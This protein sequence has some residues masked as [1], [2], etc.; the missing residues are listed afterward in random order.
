MA[1]EQS[2]SLKMNIQTTWPR[3]KIIGAE[4]EV[5]DMKWIW[6]V[7]GVVISLGHRI[8]LQLL[9]TDFK[10]IEFLSR[11]FLLSLIANQWVYTREGFFSG[12]ENTAA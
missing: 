10:K 8:N 12:P 4:V 6:E 2:M 7:Y 9:C 11:K 5:P 1:H 3:A